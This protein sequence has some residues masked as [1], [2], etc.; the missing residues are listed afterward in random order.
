MPGSVA[1]LH[2]EEYQRFLT[3]IRAM[4][5]QAGL[6]Q[7]ALAIQLGKPPSYVAKSELGERRLDVLEMLA[8]CRACDTD[9]L[10]FLKRIIRVVD[11]TVRKT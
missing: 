7:A 1:T 2:S 5:T 3:E 9:S 8:W 10:A 6:S 11:E 4:R